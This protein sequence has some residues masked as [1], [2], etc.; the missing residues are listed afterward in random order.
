MRERPRINSSAYPRTLYELPVLHLV[1]RVYGI[2][3]CA[4]LYRLLA[5][6]TAWVRDYLHQRLED[7]AQRGH[8]LGL[9]M[10]VDH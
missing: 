3:Y 9:Q 2:G 6:L 8:V 7:K 5:T 1:S 10:A 4:G